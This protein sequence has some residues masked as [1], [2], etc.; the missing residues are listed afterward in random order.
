M[1][2]PRSLRNRISRML[3]DVSGRS[4]AFQFTD[5]VW[6]ADAL[7]PPNVADGEAAVAVKGQ[8]KACGMDKETRNRWRDASGS[9]F[10]MAGTC[11][12]SGAAIY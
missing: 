7:L 1:V 9:G 3:Q 4:G 6:I 12:D 5:A 10:S 8:R 2:G 11:D